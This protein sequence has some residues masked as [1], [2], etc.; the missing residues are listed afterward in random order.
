MRMGVLKNACTCTYRRTGLKMPLINAK[1][2][3]KGQPVTHSR[4]TKKTFHMGQWQIRILRF[5]YAKLT[6]NI[7]HNACVNYLTNV[8][9]AWS[10]DFFYLLVLLILSI[11]WY[12]YTCRISAFINWWSALWLPPPPRIIL[13]K[14]LTFNKSVFH[15]TIWTFIIPN[16]NVLLVH[17]VF[18]Q[19]ISVRKVL[20]LI[21][22][23]QNCLL[24]DTKIQIMCN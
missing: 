18:P 23:L 3:G 14:L 15:K 12:I 2:K 10:I 16:I 24:F 4:C 9:I 8:V 7:Q 1:H 11:Y 19:E 20:K 13:N 17:M 21:K 5:V 6:L 22:R